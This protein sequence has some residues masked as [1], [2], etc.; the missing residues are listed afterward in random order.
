MLKNI[1]IECIQFP[2]NI[3]PSRSDSGPREK[4]NVI[5][6]FT[7]FF[8]VPQQVLTFILI[9]VNFILVQLS[10]MHWGGKYQ[11]K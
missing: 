7:F 5:F 11:V 2:T 6:I 8:V 9:K 1:L 3:S 10:E 4:I